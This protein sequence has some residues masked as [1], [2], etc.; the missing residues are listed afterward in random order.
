M[1]IEVTFNYATIKIF[2][3]FGAPR[4]IRTPISVGRSHLPY[5]LGHRR[6]INFVENYR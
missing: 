5:P 1:I 3:K 6:I 4:E 2:I